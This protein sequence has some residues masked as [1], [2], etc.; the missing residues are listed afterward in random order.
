MSR[1]STNY[2]SHDSNARNSQKILRLRIVHG[3]AG[4]GVFFMLLERLRDEDG[5]MSVKDYNTI[6]FDFR[7]DSALVKS[8]VE[9][10]G[11]FTFTEDGKRFY[12]ENFSERMGMKDEIKAK[13]KKAIQKRWE[14]KNAD[15]ESKKEKAPKQPAET[16]RSQYSSIDNDECLKRF[17][18][19]DNRASIEVL[20]MNFGM[21]PDELPAL[22][23]LA[24]EV[25]N[26]WRMSE[27]KHYDYTDWSQHLI[28]TLRIKRKEQAK[29]QRGKAKQPEEPATPPA[30]SD[31][32]FTGGFGSKDV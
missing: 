22:R 28:S 5:Y 32:Q 26:E 27:K 17:F 14:A 30:S 29:P 8:V 31:Y 13:R 20:L 4:Y 7:C 19:D 2:F 6:A 24:D 9:D 21:K 10:F 1:Q 11:L 16:P 25:V 23:K 15:A 18:A 3:C 12:S